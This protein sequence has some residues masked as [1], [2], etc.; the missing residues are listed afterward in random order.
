LRAGL[1]SAS[2]I[3]LEKSWPPTPLLLE[4]MESVG[5]NCAASLLG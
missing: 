2:C 5:L 3:A 4:S 1:L